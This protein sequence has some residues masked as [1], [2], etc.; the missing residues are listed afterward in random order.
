MADTGQ[1][2]SLR[3]VRA[4][5]ADLWR[6]IVALEEAL[7]TPVPGRATEWAAR[8]HDALTDM[9]GTFERHVA[10]TEGRDGLFAELRAFAPR[11]EGSVETLR[12][13]HEQ[14]AAMLRDELRAVRGIDDDTDTEHAKETRTRLTE[15]LALLVRHRQVGADLV[16]EAYAV[17]IGVGD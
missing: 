6:H 12:R 13:E 17:D 11:L 2:A 8:V 14:V 7:A 16:Y 3:A 10:M 15:L 4:Q 9:A 1:A 5:R